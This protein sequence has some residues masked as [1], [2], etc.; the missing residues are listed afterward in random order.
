MF[1]N[2]IDLILLYRKQSWISEPSL[3]KSGDLAFSLRR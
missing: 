3:M 1:A 2:G